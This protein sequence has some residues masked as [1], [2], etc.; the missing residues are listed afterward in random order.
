[1]SIYKTSGPARKGHRWLRISALGLGLGGL[2]ASCAREPRQPAPDGAGATHRLVVTPFQTDSSHRDPMA[3]A[4]ADSL[5]ARLSG[6]P[7]LAARVG[8]GS[9]GAD[10]VV[11]GEL[12][13]SD[14]RLV[15]A[16][17]LHR[18]PRDS[19]LWSATFWRADSLTTGLLDDLASGLDEAIYGHFARALPGS[20]REAA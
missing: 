16:A 12:A 17:R 11:R 13:G 1:M 7:D 14:G 6:M 18:S 20:T 3:R 5:V 10:F 19:A 9:S 2:L 15:I 8:T 4:L